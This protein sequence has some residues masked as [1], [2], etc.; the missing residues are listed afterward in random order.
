MAIHIEAILASSIYN[1]AASSSCSM[2]I[3]LDALWD[4]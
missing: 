2:A 4:L 1:I 3:C